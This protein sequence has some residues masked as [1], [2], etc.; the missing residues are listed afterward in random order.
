[1]TNKPRHAMT[2]GYVP[3]GATFNGTRNILPEEYFH[4]LKVGDVLNDSVMNP[5]IWP[6]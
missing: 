2:C 1:M 4:A 6:A 3:D 5:R